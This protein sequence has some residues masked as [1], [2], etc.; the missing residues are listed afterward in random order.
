MLSTESGT[1]TV[2]S[3]ITCAAV[4]HASAQCAKDRRPCHTPWTQKQAA[5]DKVARP[6]SL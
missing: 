2:P 3:L 1:N 6:M 5:A 4:S